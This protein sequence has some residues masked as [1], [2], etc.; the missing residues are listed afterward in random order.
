MSGGEIILG[1]LAALAAFCMFPLGLFALVTKLLGHLD[2]YESVSTSFLILLCFVFGSVLYLSGGNPIEATEALFQTGLPIAA[3]SG[4]TFFAISSWVKPVR[5]QSKSN[6]TLGTLIVW[7]TGIAC[8][9]AVMRVLF[10]RFHDLN[11]L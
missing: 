4:I 9:V 8:V 10:Q 5:S 7:T 6:I 3:F 2:T 1:A 11:T